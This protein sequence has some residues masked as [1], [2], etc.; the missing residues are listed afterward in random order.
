MSTHRMFILAICTLMLT[1]TSILAFQEV[2]NEDNEFSLIMEKEP[3]YSAASPPNTPSHGGVVFAEYVGATWCGPCMGYSSPSLKQLAH[4]LSN[5]FTYVSFV[6]NTPSDHNSIGRVNHIMANS[7]GYPTTAFGDATSGTYYAVGGGGSDTDG[8]GY[9][10]NQFDTQFT[11]G[12]NMVNP[13]D[14]DIKVTQVTNG[15]NLDIEIEAEY[16]GTGTAV[17]YVYAAVTEKYVP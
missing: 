5:D 16:L 13:Q 15:N 2:S 11:S 3:E 17:A 9:A 12:G 10:D 4:D 7:N 8:D 14:F 6:D 1:S